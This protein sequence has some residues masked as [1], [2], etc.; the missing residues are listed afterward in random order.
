MS[1]IFISENHPGVLLQR[2]TSL[3]WWQSIGLSSDPDDSLWSSQRTI[4]KSGANSPRPNARS[5]TAPC[6]Q[7][8]KCQDKLL[9][10]V[11]LSP[12]MSWHK[13]RKGHQSDVQKTNL[14]P[15]W[16]VSPW[17]FAYQAYHPSKPS[18]SWFSP[19]TPFWG[20][21]RKSVELQHNHAQSGQ[22]CTSC[23]PPTCWN[24]IGSC[25]GR[26]LGESC[27][28][29]TWLSTVQYLAIF[30]ASRVGSLDNEIKKTKLHTNVKQSEATWSMRPSDGC[31]RNAI[32]RRIWC[33][34]P[35]KVAKPLDTF[36]FKSKI[37]AN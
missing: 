22:G 32:W 4:C 3:E 7:Q 29:N 1:A 31:P 30:R 28:V 36:S 12:S 15:N 5:K 21:A 27:K 14:K 6:Y 17:L 2:P 25:E 8:A 23:H 10:A 33:V 24:W 13:L 19:G 16:M 11:K 34:R 20:N 26:I 18:C 37:C 35:V 9:A